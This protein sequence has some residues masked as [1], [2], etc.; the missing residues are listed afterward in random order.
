MSNTTATQ[1]ASP[2]A[3]RT[4]FRA[5]CSVRQSCTST[6]SS[7][8]GQRKEKASARNTNMLIKKMHS[9]TAKRIAQW[10]QKTRRIPTSNKANQHK[11]HTPS[12]ATTYRKCDRGWLSMV[13]LG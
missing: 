1:E 12:H 8:C 11:D 6:N 5:G 7:Q 10:K 4:R 3:A 13:D 9:A 2:S